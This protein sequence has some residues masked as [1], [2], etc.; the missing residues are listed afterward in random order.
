MKKILALLLAAAMLLVLASCSKKDNE[1]DTDDGDAVEDGAVEGEDMTNQSYWEQKYPE[2]NICPF[3]IEVNGVETSYYW[4]SS[5]VG[6]DDI[7]AWAATDLNWAGWH[8]VDGRVVDKDEKYAITDESRAQSFSSGC[9]YNT[10][11]YSK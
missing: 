11:P 9:T 6:E 4:I 5:V 2:A 1:A 3:C 10:E 8:V 7:A